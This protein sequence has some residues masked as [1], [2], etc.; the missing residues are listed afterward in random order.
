MATFLAARD[1]LHMRV[2]HDAVGNLVPRAQ[3]DV[4]GLA[5]HSG[6]LQQLLHGARHLPAEFADQFAGCAHDRLRLV[7]EKPGGANVGFEL[8][9]LK[10]GKGLW[11]RVFLEKDRRD[12]V[13]AYVGALR[14]EN[15]RDQQ[16]PRAVVM[17]SA[18]RARIALV[19]SPQDLVDA[20]R[21]QRMVTLNCRGLSL[22]GGL[23]RRSYSCGN[24]CD[25]S[26]SFP[27]GRDSIGLD[28]GSQWAVRNFV[29]TS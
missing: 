10:R 5:R 17:Q 12:Q 8:F 3:H 24:R 22:S 19:E 29:L 13:D 2:N 27:D 1:T 26:Y 18:G 25:L 14:R 11:R 7:A 15:G 16:L 9:R 6:Q 20:L 28:P 4:G 23:L 21:R